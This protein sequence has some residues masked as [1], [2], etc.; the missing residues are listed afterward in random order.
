MTT[1]IAIRPA[2]DTG[3]V[4]IE[5]PLDERVKMLKQYGTHSLSFTAFQPGMELFTIENVG[6]IAF[7]RKWNQIIVLGDPVCNPNHFLQVF[8]EF[9]EHFPQALFVQV[10][11]PAATALRECGYYTTQMGRESIVDLDT[12]SLTGKKKQIIRTACN[13]VKKD[14]ITIVEKAADPIAEAELTKSWLSSR[15]CH[16]RQIR[17]LI[18]PMHVDYEEGVRRFFAYEGDTPIGFIFFDPVYKNGMV[19][20]YIPNISRASLD[21]H[22][23]IFYAI[24][25]HAMATF[26][27]EGVRRL[28]LGLM[29]LC[30]DDPV[31]HFEGKM[32]RKVFALTRKYG[33][34]FYNFDGINFTK[35]RFRGVERPVYTAHRNRMPTLHFLTMFKLCNVYG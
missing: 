24:M 18:R 9:L 8:K 21:F 14:G 11:P 33:G 19:D 22:Q 12:W 5:T 28:Y 20:G 35:S 13:K 3:T 31:Q 17:F 27:S 29:P 25:S 26:K 16:D 4:T 23:G 15:K 6:W 34:R 32:L 10:S 2:L 1:G 7:E 30:L